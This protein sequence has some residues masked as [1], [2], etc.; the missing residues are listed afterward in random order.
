[1]T[2]LESALGSV[3]ADPGQIEQVILNLAV[4]AR[5]AMPR[6]G[7]LTLQ[8]ANV[9]LDEAYARIAG[10]EPFFTTKEVGKG[11]GLGLATV[12]GIVKQTNGHIAVDSAL[13]QG[14][15]LKVY[16][17]LVDAVPILPLVNTLAGADATVEISGATPRGTDT[18]LLVEDDDALRTLARMNGKQL[19]DRLLV[20]RPD[21]KVLFMSGYTDRAIVEYGVLEA[22]SRFLQKP[23]TPAG[24][25]TKARDVLD[26]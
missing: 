8:T 4:N 3:K 22:D 24:V 6:G 13:D 5:D 7:R 26:G 10:V 23:F 9:T 12:Y 11:T 18:V 17:P 2:S 14:A 21:L 16:L 20:E 1:M 15:T 25:G 19:A